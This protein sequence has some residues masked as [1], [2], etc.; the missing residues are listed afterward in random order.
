MTSA[1]W[2]FMAI[3]WITIFT[4]VGISMTKIV[5]TPR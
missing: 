5:K 4:T 3:I 1:A 2:G